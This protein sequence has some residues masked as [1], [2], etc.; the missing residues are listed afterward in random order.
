MNEFALIARYFKRPCPDVR[1]R[2]GIGDD[3]AGMM[4]PPGE[5]LLVTSDAL[6]AGRHF[7]LDTAPFDIGYKALAVNLSDLAAMGAK[8][9]G[10][11]LALALPQADET[12]L[13]AFAEGLFTLA[14][15]MSVCLIGGD[16]VQSPLLSLTITAL[17]SAP[18]ERVLRRSAAKV[19]DLIAVTGTIG[20]AGLGLRIAQNPQVVPAAVDARAREF[21]LGRLN[22]PRPRVGEGQQLAGFAHAAIDISDGLLQDLSHLLEQSAVGARLDPDALPLSEAAQGWLAAEPSLRQLPWRCGDDYELLFT[23]PP[24]RWADCPIPATVIGVIEA[25]SGMRWQGGD[26]EVAAIAPQGFVHFASQPA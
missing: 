9:L 4:V 5:I 24:E 8:P 3:C 12:W 1:L 16:T 17:G 15:E 13:S 22:R 25:E 26:G 2:I 10:F 20:D 7:P 23:V 18:A 21:L 11:T 19:G 6:I 14:D